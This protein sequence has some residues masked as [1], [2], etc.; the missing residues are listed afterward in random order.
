MK[1]IVKNS[2][3]ELG[4]YDSAVQQADGYFCNGNTVIPFDAI[5]NAQIIEVADDYKTPDMIA[6]EKKVKEDFNKGQAELR[7]KAYA[8]ESDPIFFKSQRGAATQ[9]EWLDKVAEIEAR[10]PY[11][12]V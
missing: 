9:Q 5:P 8:S 12:A 3:F 2:D 1:Y 4:V 7:A 6:A 11:E 10:Y